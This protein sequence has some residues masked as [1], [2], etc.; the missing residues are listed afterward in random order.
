MRPFRRGRESID[1]GLFKRRN[2]REFFS[3]ETGPPPAGPRPWKALCAADIMAAEQLSRNAGMKKTFLVE[4]L[5]ARG[6]ARIF[7]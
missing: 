4:D 3:P 1:T 6:L 2:G 5:P 7:G